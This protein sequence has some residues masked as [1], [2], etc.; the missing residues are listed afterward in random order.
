M[1]AGSEALFQ[2]FGFRREEHPICFFHALSPGTIQLAINFEF[3][4]AGQADLPGVD[5]ALELFRSHVWG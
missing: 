3:K 4:V 5:K 1:T 2:C